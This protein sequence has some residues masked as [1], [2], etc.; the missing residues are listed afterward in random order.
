[1]MMITTTT[2]LNFF[3]DDDDNDN[4]NNVNANDDDDD[5]D[6]DIHDMVMT[7]LLQFRSKNVQSSV[8]VGDD[9]NIPHWMNHRSGL[10]FIV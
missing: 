5:D 7:I 8:E 3:N 1:M 10:V 4:D 6:D 2:T 9:Y